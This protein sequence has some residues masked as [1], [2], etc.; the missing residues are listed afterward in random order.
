MRSFSGYFCSEG[1]GILLNN[2]LDGLSSDLVILLTVH[3]V[4]A[5]ALGSAVNTS[6]EAFTIELQTPGILAA[7]PFLLPIDGLLLEKGVHDAQLRG[8]WVFL[9]GSLF[10][11]FVFIKS[12]EVAQ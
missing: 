7:A 10:N 12:F 1:V 9:L 11:S 6:G 3:T 5:V 8:R 4:R 2:E